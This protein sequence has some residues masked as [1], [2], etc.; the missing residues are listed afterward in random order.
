MGKHSRKGGGERSRAQYENTI[1]D[2]TGSSR[3][4]NPSSH[5]GSSSR[6]AREQA[7]ATL[8]GSALTTNRHLEGAPAR[9]MAERDRRKQR[10][11]RRLLALA[12]SIVVLVVGVGAGALIYYNNIKGRLTNS[13]LPA[14]LKNDVPPKPQEPYNLLLLGFDARKGQTVYRTDVMILAHVNPKSKKVWMLSFPR[15]LKV[16]IKGHGTQKLNAAYAYGKEDLTIPTIEEVSGQ[17]INHYMAINFMGFEDIVDAMGGV[18]IDVPKKINDAEA[19]YTK[20]K[21]ASK[22]AKGK[23]ILDGAH[24]LTFVRSRHTYADGDFGR[25]RAQQL[26]FQ[27]VIKQMGN[28][29]LTQM[30][31]MVDAVADNVKTDLTPLQLLTVAREM[32]GIK[33]ADLYTE[34]IPSKWVS[35]YVVAN[36]TEMAAVLKKFANEQPFKEEKKD[37]KPAPKPGEIEVTVRNGTTRAGIA[38]QA[39]SVLKARG[40]KVGDVGNTDN[41]SV[42]DQTFIIYK[43]DKAAAELVAKYLPDDA[44]VVESRGM[45]AYD[46][47]ILVVLGKNW[48]LEK[49]PVD[50]KTD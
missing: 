47:E 9:L 45:Y 48:D 43:K 42:Y 32:R 37:E 1:G 28:V 8:R 44:K 41:Q 20:N 46:T 5:R 23:Q 2:R 36:E 40:F 21:T 31:G 35:P 39:A 16:E 17:T 11:R 50:V 33:P 6:I 30:P 13:N 19:D 49:I 12:V 22:I 38:K 27:A 10:R 26:F 18:E 24:A 34:T 25:M 29:S 15:D 3:G 4:L 7:N 14:V